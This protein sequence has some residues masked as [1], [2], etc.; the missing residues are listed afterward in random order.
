VESI[1]KAYPLE[2]LLQEKVVND[3][4]GSTNVVLLAS[5]NE[6]IVKT[7]ST[8]YSAGGEVRAYDRGDY[9]FEPGSTPDTV[10]SGDGRIWQVTEEAL[11]GP[12]G[13]VAPRINGHLAY[14]FGWYAFFPKTL[15]YSGE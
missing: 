3:T 13:E 10:R 8:T 1:P 2:I 5:Q 7:G 6:V 15:L 4:I 12:E 9:M 14:W 11:V